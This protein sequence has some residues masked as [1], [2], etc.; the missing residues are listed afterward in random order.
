MCYVYISLLM[1]LYLTLNCEMYKV[2]AFINIH[3]C[4]KIYFTP[5]FL[6]THHTI[7]CL[8]PLVEQF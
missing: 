4:N 5:Y 1:T 3:V 7:T 6:F 2:F 8:R